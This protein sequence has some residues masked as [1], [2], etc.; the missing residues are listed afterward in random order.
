MLTTPDVNEE[1]EDWELSYAAI[2]KV[3]WYNLFAK[4]VGSFWKS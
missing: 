4:Q 2:G 1:E 3:K